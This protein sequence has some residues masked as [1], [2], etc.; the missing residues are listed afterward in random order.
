MQEL[1][2]LILGAGWTATFLIPLLNEHKL[3]FAATTS[4]GRQVAGHPTLQWTFNPSGSEND[5]EAS[6]KSLPRARHVLIVFPLKGEG[7]SKLLARTYTATHGGAE[8]GQFRFVQLGSSGI[9]QNDPAQTPW[10]DRRSPYE[11]TGARAVAEDELLELGG[12]VLNLAGLWGGDRDVRHWFDRVATSKDAARGKKS[13]HMIHGVDV[14][15]VVLAVMRRSEKGGWDKVG[16]GQRW[17]VTDGFVYDWWSL[18]AGWA[19]GVRDE[20]AKL[21]KEPTKQARWVHELMEEEGVRALPRSMEAL[22][23]CY[24]TRELWQTIGITPLK[25]GLGLGL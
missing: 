11:R 12:C 23:R 18:F 3:L 9:W 1:D 17:M 13:L 14:A 8:E 24:D 25:A 16:K 21:D 10:L 15:R 20:G 5:L 19:E 2:I 7:Q 4:D 22:G 6:F